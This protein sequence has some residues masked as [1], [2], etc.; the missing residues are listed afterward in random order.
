MSNQ[1]SAMSGGLA[2]NAVSRSSIDGYT[3]A[4]GGRLGGANTSGA[5]TGESGQT[6]SQASGASG[7]ADTSSGA[8]ASNQDAQA[9]GSSSNAVAGPSTAT[10]AP[11]NA[12]QG[13]R[14]RL[15][16]HL[17]AARSLHFEP[18]ERELRDGAPAIKIGRFT[19][20]G[21]ASAGTGAGASGSAN[22]NASSSSAAAGSA[23]G[24][25]SREGL[26]T[27]VGTGAGLGALTLGSNA[28]GT[29]GE[30]GFNAE[31]SAA[32]PSAGGV[33]G[34]P[35]TLTTGGRRQVPDRSRSGVNAN[36][37]LDLSRIAFKSKVV[38]RGHAEI[39]C[40]NGGTFFL[41]D[42]KSSSG[43]FLN[44]IRLSAPGVESRP[45]RIKDGDVVQLGVDYQGG[46]EEIYRCVKM[47]VELN[48][49]WQ[50]EANQY[51]INALRQLRALQGS[52]MPGTPTGDG[53]EKAIALG[54]AASGT[55]SAV[56][57]PPTSVTDC[58]I[59]L[60]SVT[61]CQALFIAP[62]SH[63][64]HYKCIRPL[65][66]QHHPGFSCPLCRTFA[67][68]EADVEQE[69]EWQADLI[70]QATQGP[71]VVGAATP[72]ATPAP[73]ASAAPEPM[74]A[75]PTLASGLAAP[76]GAAS[77][78]SPLATVLETHSRPGSEAPSQDRP[79]RGSGSEMAVDQNESS[80]GPQQNEDE[81]QQEVL[82]D[83]EDELME[84]FDGPSSSS[85]GGRYSST[86]DEVNNDSSQAP[87]QSQ[88]EFVNNSNLS[89]SA[90]GSLAAR[91][92]LNNAVLSPAG[93][94]STGTGGGVSEPITM[95]ISANAPLPGNGLED[96]RTPMN[97]HFLS[98]LAE[99][100]PGGPAFFS[101]VAAR[102]AAAAA[103]AGGAGLT[104]GHSPAAQQAAADVDIATDRSPPGIGGGQTPTGP[105]VKREALG[106]GEVAASG[107]GSSGEEANASAR[108]AV[109]SD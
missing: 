7:Q 98:T 8:H 76:A 11:G 77:V 75:Q 85:A 106:N 100:T 99:S 61:V 29:G 95:P 78:A 52:P 97:Q 39:W 1:I 32:G 48:R 88:A 84:E 87:S 25:P 27:A 19:E 21:A 34:V 14:I 71:E 83:D 80:Q 15:V 105:G 9:A 65:I 49:G 55:V 35:S 2:S 12:S 47:R 18:I 28:R 104:N 31:S 20:R 59:C 44:H 40:E 90:S 50:R 66:T 56:P 92:S 103:A 53:N 91:R 46:T 10:A 57:Q 4:T 24:T 22:A 5:A 108:D 54:G 109:M 68:L 51:N 81:D 89:L 60:F 86:D 45:H 33:E 69:E 42:T 37:K 17:E 38:S 72:S 74:S 16:P 23:F 96:A 30:A 41:R 70:R 62:C 79:N 36:N 73:I 102:A 58:C 107:A 67:D 26:G 93:A 101:A 43:T 82:Q 94:A 6:T 63:V 64:F 13:Y 3:A